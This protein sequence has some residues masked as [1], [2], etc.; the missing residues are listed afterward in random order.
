MALAIDFHCLIAEAL[1]NR[2]PTAIAGLTLDP[3]NDALSTLLDFIS[4]KAGA[5]F[6]FAHEHRAV[7]DA[8]SARKP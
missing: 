3:S 6:A 5:H 8:I 2:M 7:G 1:H 4:I